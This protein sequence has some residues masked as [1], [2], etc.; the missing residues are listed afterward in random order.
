MELQRI[1]LTS[2][3]LFLPLVYIANPIVA[4][5]SPATEAPHEK[6]FRKNVDSRIWMTIKKGR[7]MPRSIRIMP[8]LRRKRGFVI[9]VS[10]R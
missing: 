8:R 10:P 5:D 2:N 4:N 1:W 9:K 6:K 7:K 3:Q